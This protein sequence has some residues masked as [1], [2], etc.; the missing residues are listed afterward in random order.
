[1]LVSYAQSTDRVKTAAFGTLLRSAVFLLPVTLALGI[2]LPSG[3]WWLFP[4]TEVLSL[5][6]LLPVWAFRQKKEARREVP[7]VSRTMTNDNQELGNVVEAVEQFCEENGVPTG[8]SLQLQLAV[9]ELCAVTMAQAFSGKSGEY[10]RV[11]L[12]AEAGPRY[13]LHIRNSAPYFNPLDMRMGQARMDMTA[14]IMDSIGVMM[15]RKKAKSLSFRN[16]QGYN[17]LTVEY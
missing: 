9:E 1:M 4:V 10:I 13:V 5:A 14:E 3:F 12:A 8:T 11:T 16:Y 15:V 2:F 6:V 7:V 17:V